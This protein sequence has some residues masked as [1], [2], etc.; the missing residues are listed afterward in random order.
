MEG[1]E[2]LWGMLY[3]RNCTMLVGIRNHKEFC[4]VVVQG[5]KRDFRKD[6]WEEGQVLEVVT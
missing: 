5:T 4:V 1:Q 2:E 3:K 6:V